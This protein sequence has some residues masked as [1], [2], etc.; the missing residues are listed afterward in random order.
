MIPHLVSLAILE[1][2]FHI[3][4][5]F[6]TKTVDALLRLPFNGYALTYVEC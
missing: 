4:L 6:V 3:G 5:G 1:S 2:S